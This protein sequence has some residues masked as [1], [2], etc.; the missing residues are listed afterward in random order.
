MKGDKNKLTINKK[1][2]TLCLNMTSPLT[3]MSS[4]SSIDFYS[5]TDNNRNVIKN[6]IK[7]SKDGDKH[8]YAYNLSLNK[9]F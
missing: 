9:F 7:R 6:H 8:M 4:L 2:R 5:K 3:F 1:H